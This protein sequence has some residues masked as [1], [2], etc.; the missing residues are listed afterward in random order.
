[1][2]ESDLVVQSHPT[3]QAK[4][5]HSLVIVCMETTDSKA[6]GCGNSNVGVEMFRQMW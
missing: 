6:C 3:K 4:H 1:M 2:A 5:K